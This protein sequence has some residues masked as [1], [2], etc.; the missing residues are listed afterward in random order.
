M[1]QLF[2]RCRRS[3]I[4]SY[5]ASR[6]GARPFFAIR[7]RP[8]LPR[9]VERTYTDHAMVLCPW[10]PLGGWGP[11]SAPGLAPA[12]GPGSEDGPQ[13]PSATRRAPF[14]LRG[15]I[16]TFPRRWPGPP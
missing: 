1:L 3:T 6:E 15:R 2:V 7:E 14:S 8:D 9:K 5:F 16:T 12:R 11:S 10:A 4:L 13:P